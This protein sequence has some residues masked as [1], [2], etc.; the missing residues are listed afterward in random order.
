MLGHGETY[1]ALASPQPICFSFSQNASIDALCPN[2]SLLHKWL[3]SV[4]NV[5]GGCEETEC[6]QRDPCCWDILILN[7][8]YENM[9]S[10][11][12]FSTRNTRSSSKLISISSL[13]RCTEPY[14]GHMRKSWHWQITFKL[15]LQ[16]LLAFQPTWALYQLFHVSNMQSGAAVPSNLVCVSDHRLYNCF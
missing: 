16:N 15:W 14:Q 6:V 13:Q 11:S 12:L 5:L 4:W 10:P 9:K 8:S 7:E 2:M 3:R 1:K